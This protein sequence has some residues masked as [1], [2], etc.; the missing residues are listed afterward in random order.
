MTTRDP[1]L[2]AGPCP[3]SR[4]ATVGGGWAA[5]Y[6][7]HWNRCRCGDSPEDDVRAAEMAARLADRAVAAFERLRARGGGL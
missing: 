2:P 4:L 3:V 6:A 5:A 1:G 7:E